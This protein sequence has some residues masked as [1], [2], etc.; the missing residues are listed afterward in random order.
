MATSDTDMNGFQNANL[1]TESSETQPPHR[2]NSPFSFVFKGSLKNHEM[3]Q[4]TMLHFNQI[5]CPFNE[6]KDSMHKKER[7][8][9]EPNLPRD[10]HLLIHTQTCSY[11]QVNNRAPVPWGSSDTQVRT[12]MLHNFLLLLPSRQE[13][14]LPTAA[15][16]TTSSKVST[17]KKRQTDPH[18]SPNTLYPDYLCR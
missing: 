1:N 4:K 18:S 15:L 10:S 16:N 11:F 3:V 14:L 6:G 5:A 17:I 8:L 12:L 2:C 13:K 9:V 7:I